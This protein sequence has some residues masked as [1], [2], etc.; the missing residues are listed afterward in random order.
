MNKLSLLFV[1]LMTVLLSSCRTG[2]VIL[3]ETPLNLSETRRVVMSVI[4]E[5]RTVSQNGREMTSRFY[6]KKGSNIEKMDMAK[7]R[8]Y[9]HVTILGDR[10]PYD[11]Q[12]QVLVEGR[13]EDGG[14]DLL[15]RDDERAAPIA[16]K[17]RQTLNQ[18]RD[19]RNVIDDFRSF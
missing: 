1:F 8:F 3:R 18:S 12:V 5:P 15:D 2:G 7:E 13:N 6:D 10:R 11:V 4:G 16:E 19:S 9:T 14:F 17:L